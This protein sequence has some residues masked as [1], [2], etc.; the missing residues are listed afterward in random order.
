MMWGNYGN[1][2]NRTFFILLGKLLFSEAEIFW[3]PYVFKWAELLLLLQTNNKN[4]LIKHGKNLSAEKLEIRS[5]TS[6]WFSLLS[7]KILLY[8]YLFDLFSFI[9]LVYLNESFSS[10]EGVDKTLQPLNWIDWTT[11]VKF[12]SNCYYFSVGSNLPPPRSFWWSGCQQDYA[13]TTEPISTEPGGGMGPGSTMN[14]S[15]FGADPDL[16]LWIWIFSVESGVC[17]LILALAEVSALPRLF[18]VSYII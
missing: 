13:E 18:L 5:M 9:L 1:S 6:L 7:A 12:S 4:K 3:I 14:P 16:L 8:I 10:V 2:D 17:C 11:D 15:H